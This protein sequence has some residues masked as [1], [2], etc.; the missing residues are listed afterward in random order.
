MV[1][2]HN[3]V[4]LSEADQSLKQC[5]VFIKQCLLVS[6]Y[7]LRL[8]LTQITADELMINPLDSLNQPVTLSF[9]GNLSTSEKHY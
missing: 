1:P 5:A 7:R 3:R 8:S 2:K 9:A 4:R 6:V